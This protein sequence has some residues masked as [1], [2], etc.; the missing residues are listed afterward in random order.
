VRR[1]VTVRQAA[2]LVRAMFDSPRCCAHLNAVL[3]YGTLGDHLTEDMDGIAKQTPVLRGHGGGVL[4]AA[5]VDPQRIQL[6]MLGVYLGAVADVLKE[7]G[8]Y[9]EPGAEV[10]EDGV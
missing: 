3:G 1:A 5:R 2:A 9:E 7:H 6:A 10:K 4:A 8:L